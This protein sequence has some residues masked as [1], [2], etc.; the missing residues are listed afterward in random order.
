MPMRSGSSGVQCWLSTVRRPCA[1]TVPC[2]VTALAFSGTQS[3]DAGTHSS[4]TRCRNCRIRSRFASGLDISLRIRA[5]SACWHSTSVCPW[6]MVRTTGRQLPD[7]NALQENRN[8]IMS[9]ISLM[10]CVGI[11]I[12]LDDGSCVLLLVRAFPKK[13][14]HAEEHL[15]APACSRTSR[16]RPS[17]GGA[18]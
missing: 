15:P 2:C 4:S 7:A 3:R 10:W 17:S 6:N 12:T 18:G 13:N 9:P 16:A 1:C 14:W 5:S 11:T 8:P